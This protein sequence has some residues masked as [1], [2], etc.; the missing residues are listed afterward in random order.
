MK[1]KDF[2]SSAPSAPA[3]PADLIALAIE[4]IGEVVP[5]SKEQSARWYLRQALEELGK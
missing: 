4:G 1:A 5:G 2:T 3:S